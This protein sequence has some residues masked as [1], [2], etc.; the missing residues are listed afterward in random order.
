MAAN[1]SFTQ[2]ALASDQSF[3]LR[4]RAALARVAWEMLE[5][6]ASTPNHDARVWYAK[7][8]LASLTNSAQNVAPWLVERPNLILFETSYDF[9]AQAVITAAGDADIESQLRTD[10]DH[11]A[12]MFAPPTPPGPPAP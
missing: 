2:Q 6:P 9:S 4:V 12:G 10:W 11:L 1:D 3:Q 7:Y 8:V 5:E